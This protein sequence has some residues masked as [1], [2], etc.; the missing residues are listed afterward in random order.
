M[1]RIL[2]ITRSLNLGGSQRQLIEIARSLDKSRFEVTVAVFYEGGIFWK[3]MKGT[4]GVSLISLGKK[5]R[6]D[7]HRVWSSARGIVRAWHPDVVYGFREEGSIL[8]L[9][10]ARL[11]RAKLVWGI[12]RSSKALPTRDPFAFGLFWLGAAMS[13][14]ADKVVY[15]SL[16]GLETH[17]NRG[18]SRHNALVVPNGFDTA[19]FRLVPKARRRIR[20]SWSAGHGEV[21]IGIVGRLDPVKGHDMFLRT[22]A[23]VAGS[24][25]QARF[26]I[27]GK[28]TDHY[29]QVLKSRAEYLG[30]ADRVMWAGECSRMVDVYNALDVLALCSSEEGCPNVVGEA[31]ACGVPCA[32]NDV[33]D[34]ARMI[35]DAG[36]VVAPGSIEAMAHAWCSL[37]TLSEDDRL[38]LGR[39]ARSRIIREYSLE[40]MVARTE[41]LLEGLM[42]SDNGK[43]KR[44]VKHGKHSVHGDGS[45]AGSRRQEGSLPDRSRP[46]PRNSGYGGSVSD[47]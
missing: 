16:C 10:L 39:R 36:M 42:P 29:L 15:N 18:Y 35:G 19:H 17:A 26:V 34:A 40:L 46:I 41:R 33:G 3:D 25:P 6:W 2:F 24:H 32:V 20:S 21:L 4:P 23:L 44:P 12:R 43:T 13:Y 5:S 28:G 47:R 38:A 11:S 7:L 30:V 14:A 45:P 8:A 37:M 1:T 9:P 22:A 31:M 27:V